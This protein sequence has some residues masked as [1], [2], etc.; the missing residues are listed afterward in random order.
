MLRR[1]AHANAGTRIDPGRR[2][3]PDWTP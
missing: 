2:K 3:Q 1:E